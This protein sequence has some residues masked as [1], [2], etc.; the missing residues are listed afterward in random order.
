MTGPARALCYRLA[1]G[2]GLRYAEIA[3]ISPESFDWTA[4]PATV[5]VAAGYT[6]N[7]QPA[8]LPL[9]ADL[10]D[11]LAAYVVTVAPGTAVFPLPVEK[12]A[13]M[14]RA[15]LAR[16]GSLTATRQDWFSTSTRYVANA[17]PWPI[18]LA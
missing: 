6:K 15:D 4:S 16:A 9:P 11:D 14:L 3:S 8:T 10:A 18:K 2:T 1:V 7:G 17:P 13:K 5:T 12:G